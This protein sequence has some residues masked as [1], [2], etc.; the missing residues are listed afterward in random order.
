LVRDETIRTWPLSPSLFLPSH[1]FVEQCLSQDN[2]LLS[3]ILDSFTM[4]SSS[5]RRSTSPSSSQEPQSPVSTPA[6]TPTGSPPPPPPPAP[7]RPVPGTFRYMPRK[8]RIVKWSQ[9]VKGEPENHPVLILPHEGL[10]PELVRVVF[11]TSVDVVGKCKAKKWGCM[12]LPLEGQL[13]PWRDAIPLA[14]GSFKKDSSINVTSVY[15]VHWRDLETLDSRTVDRPDL[16]LSDETFDKVTEFV[17]KPEADI[18]TPWRTRATVVESTAPSQVSVAPASPAMRDPVLPT[19]PA[20]PV[21]DPLPVSVA[22]LAPVIAQ[23]TAEKY[24]VPARRPPA[25][26][27]GPWRVGC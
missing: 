23:V 15:E 25:W 21:R 13:H 3:S 17:K 24:V 12:Y 16:C 4:M 6:T 8:A 26:C 5:W 7:E 22:V 14:L 9:K 27:S 1:R 2:T 19:A 20:L 11:A 10:A 18:N